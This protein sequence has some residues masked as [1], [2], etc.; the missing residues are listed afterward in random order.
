MHLRELGN[1]S[2]HLSCCVSTRSLLPLPAFPLTSTGGRQEPTCQAGP[3]AR[4]LK[5]QL[6]AQLP[7]SV[8]CCKETWVQPYLG[9]WVVVVVVEWGGEALGGSCWFS[10]YVS[11][12]WSSTFPLPLGWL[13]GAPF[14]RL[15]SAAYSLQSLSETTSRSLKSKEL[16]DKGSYPWEPQ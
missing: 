13:L 10:W 4:L 5:Q 6:F 12:L 1:L 15:S 8:L 9:G 16:K 7:Q 14:D 3:P 11:A 2:L